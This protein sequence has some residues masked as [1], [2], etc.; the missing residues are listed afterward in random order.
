MT[1]LNLVIIYW[2][3]EIEN[4]DNIKITWYFDQMNFPLSLNKNDKRNESLNEIAQM[5]YQRL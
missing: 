1:K 4:C 3:C 2:L 5:Q